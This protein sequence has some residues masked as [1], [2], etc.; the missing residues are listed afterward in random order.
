V[1]RGG[2]LGGE[3]VNT[4]KRVDPKTERLIARYEAKLRRTEVSLLM[5]E[6]AARRLVVI[7]S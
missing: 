3:T 5:A 2:L 7:D 4:E 1:L 6:G